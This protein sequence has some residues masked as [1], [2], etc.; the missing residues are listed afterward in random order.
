ML[1]LFYPARFC[2]DFTN[3]QNLKELLRKNLNA[4]KPPEQSEGFGG[5]IGCKDKSLHGI[6]RLPQCYHIGRVNS[7]IS[8]RNPPLYCTLILITM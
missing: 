7:I 1:K 6:K 5:N 8:G 2:F 4:A 3:T